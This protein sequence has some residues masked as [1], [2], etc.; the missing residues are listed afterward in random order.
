[1]CSNLVFRS[2]DTAFMVEN[3]LPAKGNIANALSQDAQRYFLNLLNS[4]LKKLP[5][6]SCSS[7]S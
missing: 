3:S 2:L 4:L 5:V 1:M 6:D 7:D